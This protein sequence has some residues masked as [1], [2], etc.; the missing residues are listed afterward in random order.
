MMIQENIIQLYSLR[1]VFS[2]SNVLQ[3][4][5]SSSSYRKKLYYCSPPFRLSFHQTFPFSTTF[6]NQSLNFRRNTFSSLL[7][8]SFSSLLF[9]L[10]LSLS[11]HSIFL[12]AQFTCFGLLPTD[13][14]VCSFHLPMRVRL[15]S[16]RLL[17]TTMS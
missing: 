16:L 6:R 2:S 1:S 8:I 15:W 9:F 17:S 10:F 13:P 7:A 11:K 5:L 12:H 14:Y 3:T 4:P